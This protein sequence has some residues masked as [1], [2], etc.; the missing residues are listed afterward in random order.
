[1]IA[2]GVTWY[3]SNNCSGQPYLFDEIASNSS[4]TNFGTVDAQGILHYPSSGSG[5]DGGTILSQLVDGSC[6]SVS[7]APG[8]AIFTPEATID[9]NTL[10]LVPPFRLQ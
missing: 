2:P 9:L 1:M 7:N 6:S 5:V 4:M 3:Q 8:V 10:G